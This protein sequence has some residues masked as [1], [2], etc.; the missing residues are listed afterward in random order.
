MDAPPPDFSEKLGVTVDRRPRLSRFFLALPTADRLTFFTRLR[1]ANAFPAGVASVIVAYVLLATAAFLFVRHHRGLAT[2]QWVDMVLPS[3][4]ARYHEARG[5]QH[6]ETAH[7]R[8]REGHWR[9]AFAYLSAGLARAPANRDGRLLMA[10][11]MLADRRPEAA[12]TLMLAGL[13]FHRND[14]KF[15]TPLFSLLL[16]RQEDE[17]VVALAREFLAE[18]TSGERANLAALSGASASFLRGHYD[19]AE[20]FLRGV[21]GL[22]ESRDGRLLAAKIDWDRGY[23]DLALL[24]LRGL[25]A[26][27]PQH[28]EPHTEL[29]RRLRQTDRRDEA[30]RATV[31]FQ[32]AHPTLPQPRIE[33]L[34]A[35][36]DEGDPARLG[37]EI[38]D[39]LRNFSTD[40]PTLLRLGGFA[41]TAGDAP[42]ARRLLDHARARNLPWEPH[43]VLVVEATVV[44]GDYR[45]ALEAIRALTS[46]NPH[47]DH[48]YQAT[49]DSLQAISFLGAGELE[50]SRVLLTS[51]LNRSSLRADNLIEVANRF[52]ALGADDQARQVLA[53]AIV[54]DPLNQAALTRLVEFDLNLN[55]IDELPA[56][57]R[58]LVAMRRP[59]PDILRVAQHKLGSDLFLFS[60]ER[61]PALDAVRVALEKTR[62]PPRR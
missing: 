45:A 19:R 14:P 25:V 15:L 38:D 34:Q 60:G 13:P 29:I 53:R 44:A 52:A 56:H 57:L 48:R 12:Q 28:V 1:W 26:Q 41:A 7:A 24:Q 21:P 23:R 55:R 8:V 10:D 5:T 4:W 37:R 49:L 16:Y 2:V 47:W 36:R 18:G 51:F 27:F 42:L 50:A 6:I 59:S 32:F 22:I 62:T 20:D 43:A 61:A 54:V 39:L 46:E 58:R 9:E 30:R 33:L 11:L 31:S 35:Y 17:R 3:R 40:A